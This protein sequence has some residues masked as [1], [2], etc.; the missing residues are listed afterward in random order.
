M[1]VYVQKILFCLLVIFCSGGILPAIHADTLGEKIMSMDIMVARKALETLKDVDQPTFEEAFRY[2]IKKLD[3]PYRLCDAVD[4]MGRMYSYSGKKSPDLQK[5]MPTLI[6]LLKDPKMRGNRTK[7]MVITSLGKFGSDAMD[8]VPTLIDTM[9]FEYSRDIAS[10]L[11]II[12]IGTDKAVP[13]VPVLREGLKDQNP[14]WRAT[15]ANDLGLIGP[16]AKD[17]LPDLQEALKDSNDNVRAAAADAIKAINQSASSVY[18]VTTATSTP[19]VTQTT[20][21]TTAPATG[22]VS[23][24]QPEEAATALPPDDSSPQA[25]QDKLDGQATA[26]GDSVRLLAN[27][28]HNQNSILSEMGEAIHDA[29]ADLYKDNKAT[30]VE[31]AD[32]MGLAVQQG[33]QE[34]AKNPQ[35]MWDRH[36][37][38]TYVLTLRALS[39]GQQFI[40]PWNLTTMQCYHFGAP[41]GVKTDMTDDQ[42]A[43]FLKQ[44]P[45]VQAIIASLRLQDLYSKYGK[46]GPYSLQAYFDL[47]DFI[48]GKVGQG[49]WDDPVTPSRNSVAD[50][51]ALAATGFFA[52]Q[53]LLGSKAGVEGGTG[54]LESPYGI[55]YWLWAVHDNDG[56]KRSLLTWRD[57]A[58]AKWDSATASAAMTGEPGN[59]EIKKEDNKN[60]Q[61]G[62]YKGTN[63]QYFSDLNKLLDEVAAMPGR[64]F[65]A[66]AAPAEAAPVP[67][68]VPTTAPTVPTVVQTKAKTIAPTATPTKVIV[69]AT[70]TPVAKAAGM[71]V[72][73]TP[74]TG[75]VSVTVIAI[76]WAGLKSTNVDVRLKALHELHHVGDQADKV[77][78]ML[79]D[80]M[81]TGDGDVRAEA[82]GVFG[83]L[84]K[85]D[86]AAVP[87]LVKALKSDDPGL[88]RVA[89]YSLIKIGPPEAN[90]AVPALQDLLQD[91]DKLIQDLAKFALKKIAE[92]PEVSAVHTPQPA[93]PVNVGPVPTSTSTPGA[94]AAV[95]KPAY[96]STPVAALIPVI[97]PTA[98]PTPR[99][100]PTEDT[101]Q[102]APSS[103]TFK[104]AW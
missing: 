26:F 80:A 36:G 18:K 73:P 64:K 58:K 54:A 2:A 50:P 60:P 35:Q 88:K 103:S 86:A 74:V 15:F 71:G 51:K 14:N 46:R 53:V 63:A 7:L 24:G 91:E 94:A 48:E 41:Y 90:E 13:A 98:K 70:K 21:P 59:F 5:V 38:T 81:K 79:I 100:V 69:M 33:Y 93:K 55:L 95:T 43:D 78:P 52:K 23:Q 99:T 89:I 57:Q 92:Q 4:M 16:G 85:Q 72:A 12:C 82:A 27:D 40:G 9:K 84:D 31:T 47:G 28:W 61:S 8:A 10:S 67:T 102:Q 19:T 42:L 49:K 34:I 76:D 3:D 104:D 101:S 1:R 39:V 45:K 17:A 87:L 96:T 20:A 83:D 56:I 25:M 44:N 22:A 65:A 62:D 77:I 97:V 66:A 29:L 6:G 30:L 68:I 75:P 11:A 37:N 32:L